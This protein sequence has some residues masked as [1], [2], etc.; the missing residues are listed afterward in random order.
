MKARKLISI[1]LVI[2]LSVLTCLVP[3]AYAAGAAPLIV[4]NGFFSTPLYLNY[5][6][7]DQIEIFGQERLVGLV[8]D[9]SGT[10]VSNFQFD[11]SIAESAVG[12]LVGAFISG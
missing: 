12:K 7:D 9:L 8:G 6:T 5:G 2:V 10:D 4:V 11:P 3:T 1:A